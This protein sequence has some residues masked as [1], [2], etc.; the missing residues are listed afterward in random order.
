MAKKI[1]LFTF[2]ILFISLVSATA[3]VNN[4]YDF[5]VGCGGY[6]CSKLNITILF[7]NS[8]IYVQNGSMTNQITHANYSINAAVVGNYD[9]YLF[10][11]T[12]YGNGTITVTKTGDEITLQQSIIYSL[13][14]GMFIFLFIAGFFG[15]GFL[16]SKNDKDEEGQII[17]I[18]NLKYLRTTLWIFQYFFLIAI[19]FIAGTIGISYVPNSAVGEVL[20]VMFKILFGIAPLV[21]TLLVVW[22]IAQ[23]IQDR[24]IRNL[25]ERG[26]FPQG[27]L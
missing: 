26:M 9:Y 5:T 15:I 20:F 1:I 17:S 8:T 12:D 27:K 11:G 18:N 22:L 25:W 24:R 4:D 2:A 16:P 7:P 6:D 10:D 21:I 3:T 14:L 13:L 23:I 19:V